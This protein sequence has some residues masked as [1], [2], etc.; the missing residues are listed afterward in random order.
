MIPVM[1]VSMMKGPYTLS[2][3]RVQNVVHLWT[4]TDIFQGDTCPPD[5]AVVGIELTTYMKRALMTE[6]YRVQK[7]LIILYLMKRLH[8]EF[9]INHLICIR[10]AINEGEFVHL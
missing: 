3:L 9:L 8:T 6:N 5:P 4:V 7:S 1:V 10:K 2:L